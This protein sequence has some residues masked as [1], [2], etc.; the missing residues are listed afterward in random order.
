MVS[1][2]AIQPLSAQYPLT[3]DMKSPFVEVVKN[4]RES[5]V[6]IQ[7]EF[8][9][10]VAARNQLPFDD[11]FFKFFFPY[12]QIQSRKSVAMGSGFIFEQDGRNVFIMTNNH[13]VEHG[14][15]GEITVTLADKAK[16]KAEIVGL[17]SESDLAVIKIKVDKGEQIT[18]A[19][20]GDSDKL[21][22]GDWAIAIG[23]PFGQLGLERTVT[24][25][26][27]SATGRAGL[28]FGSD[29]PLYQDYIQTDAA[30]NPGN[31]GGPLLNL[32]G[33]V[34]GVNAAITSTSG[35]NVGI[36]FAI[37]VNLA[38]K[39]AKDLMEKGQV[40]RAYIGILPQEID[41]D[42]RQ[43]L[44]LDKV[45]GVLVSKVE[46]DTPAEKAGLKRGDVI[47]EFDNVEIPNVAKFRIMIANSEIGKEYPLKVIRNNKEKTLKVKLVARPDLDDIALDRA[48]KK[49]ASEL[50]LQV[51]S[52]KGEF[53]QK[54]NIDEDE[55]VVI[56]KIESG[57]PAAES[58]LSVGDIILEINQ[59]KIESVKDFKN[60]TK[61]LKEG[62]ILFYIKT[63]RGNYQYVTVKLD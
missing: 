55:G 61:D 39:V 37:P 40:I 15:D 46:E 12:P 48:D 33:E 16:Y 25:G 26:V 10:S 14:K 3:S 5:V 44:K 47:I 38:K 31:S 43:S 17:D 2:V 23:N 29:S 1:I 20:L 45:K 52:A 30:I 58:Q 60:A 57:S 41:S 7:V 28:N 54:Y 59:Q 63:T 50:G 42:L 62:I 8:E 4:I 13:V 19:K 35:G 9:Q 49:Q 24:V 22:I 32:N 53:A 51:E 36:G 56:T 6:N 18:I 27:I 34:I 11:D 21:E